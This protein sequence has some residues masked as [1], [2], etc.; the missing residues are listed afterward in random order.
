MAKYKLA[1][2]IGR[3]QPL[4]YG[5]I[6]LFENALHYSD[7]VLVLVGSSFGGQSHRNPFD[8]A[9]RSAWI[10]NSFPGND[11]IN[12][13]GISDYPHSDAEWVVQTTKAILEFDL[14]VAADEIC[15]IGHSK[16]ES[17][18]YLEHFPFDYIDVNMHSHF[19][20]TDLREFIYSGK[21][22]YAE[23]SIPPHVYNYLVDYSRTDECRQ[24]SDERDYQI[25][26]MKPYDLL[27][28]PPV[29]VTGDAVVLCNDHILLI[30]RG[31]VHGYGQWALPGGY[32][33]AHELIETCILRE[34]EEESSF[35]MSTNNAKL[36]EVVM[37]DS[38]SRSVMARS[39]THAGLVLVSSQEELPVLAHS[40]DA[41]DA[42]WFHI[43]SLIS[44]R[45][46]IFLDHY[47][48]MVDLIKR[49]EKYRD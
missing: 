16:D 20:A 21:L 38:P 18:S 10:K 9:Q 40:D 23:L 14:S 43:N 41:I 12:T 49:S 2:V 34:L 30:K 15:I 1:V 8:Y 37:F 28:F 24:L 19:H 25:E 22:Q 31:N 7:N 47:H 32:L 27:D 13:V 44:L 17:S 4:H 42:K 6:H 35:D 26:Y 39:I 3:F 45:T 11:S 36:V 46:N 48:I 33:D 29:F 5:H